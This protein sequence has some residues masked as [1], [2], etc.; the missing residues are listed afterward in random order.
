[1]YI[2]VLFVLKDYGR[3]D[4]A[5]FLLIRS[6]I[7]LEVIFEKTDKIIQSHL[8]FG[9]VIAVHRMGNM[10]FQGVIAKIPQKKIG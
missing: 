9:I 6:G 7:D 2:I 8:K 10:D 3:I 5:G 4:R 1:V